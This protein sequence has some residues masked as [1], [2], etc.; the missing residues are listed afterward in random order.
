MNNMRVQPFHSG[1]WIVTKFSGMSI[2]LRVKNCP[3]FDY[4]SDAIT[5]M[6]EVLSGRNQEEER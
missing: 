3:I 4:E 1:G 2:W 6:Q 5:C